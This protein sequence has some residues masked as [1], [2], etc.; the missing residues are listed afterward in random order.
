MRDDS[1]EYHVA[2][3]AKRAE[4]GG[5]KSAGLARTSADGNQVRS[6]TFQFVGIIDASVVPTVGPGVEGQTV[7]VDANGQLRRGGVAGVDDLVGFAHSDGSVVVL[8]GGLGS[9]G[10]PQGPPGPPG[11]QGP[12]GPQGPQG[13]Q[14]PPG[15]SDIDADLG[16][17]I[18]MSAVGPKGAPVLTYD[19]GRIQIDSTL[20]AYLAFGDP[21][22]PLPEDGLIR[23]SRYPVSGG[24][25]PSEAVNIIGQIAANG[26]GSE[27]LMR[28][29]VLGDLVVGTQSRHTIIGGNGIT[30]DA[31][32]EVDGTLTVEGDIVITD[33][34]STTVTSA[35]GKVTVTDT[36]LS[37]QTTDGTAANAY[38]WTIADEAITTV[39]VLVTAITSTGGAGASYKRSVTFRR[40]GGTVSTI[41][42]V[43]DNATDEDSSAWDVTIDNSTST[44]RV[45]ITGAAATTIRWGMSIRIQTTVP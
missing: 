39:D 4:L 22:D 13:P 31:N 43:R 25:G 19:E 9:A 40:D 30:L 11:P 5:R 44:G 18:Y 15:E 10:G 32:T 24:E 3:A 26:L 20:G 34:T 6:F 28:I 42:A 33:F 29:N 2:T 1:G 45:R 41:G 17:V 38:T 21:E 7:Y 27:S 23:L 37:A 8:F 36:I 16:Q 12:E 14:G 35:D